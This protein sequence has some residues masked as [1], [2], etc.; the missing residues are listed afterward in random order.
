MP[1]SLVYVSQQLPFLK[2]ALIKKAERSKERKRQTEHVESKL[3]SMRMPRK[4]QI[5]SI[6][7]DNM[8]IPGV[9]KKIGAV[10]GEI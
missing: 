1:I 3:P 6:G 10:L 9:M 5:K 4:H 7:F 8:K 2:Y